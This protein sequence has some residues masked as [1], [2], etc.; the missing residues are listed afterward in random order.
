MDGLRD[1]RVECIPLSRRYRSNRGLSERLIRE[2]LE[3]Q[4]WTVWRGGMLDIVRERGIPRA[5]RERYE[6][7]CTLLDLHMPGTREQ[8][9][10]FCAVQHGMPDFLCYRSGSFLWVECKLGHESLSERQK[11]CLLKLRWMGFRVEVHRL[12]YPQTRSRQLSLNLLTGRKDIRERQA[13]LK[14]I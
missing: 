13:T 2:R 6:Q 7:L 1:I 4:G 14:R 5:L 12:V 3:K 10:Y 8:L 11:L 9:Q